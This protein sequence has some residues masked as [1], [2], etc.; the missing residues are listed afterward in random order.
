MDVGIARLAE[1]QHGV[2]ARRQLIAIG[3]DRNRIR[4]RLEQGRLHPIHRGVYAVGHRALTR[5]GRWMAAVLACGPGAA[6]SHRAAAALWGLRSSAAAIDVSIT[7]R[8]G[9]E[10]RCGIVLH[11]VQL[12]RSEVTEHAGIPVTTPA[13]VLLDLAAILPPRDIARAVEA[14]ERARVFDLDALGELFA[15]YP[16]RP[17]TKALTTAI[18]LHRPDL[19]LTRSE[20]ERRFLE[21][22]DEHGVDAPL[23]N[24]P[25]GPYVADFLWPG[26]R[27]IVESDGAETHLT[28]TAFERDRI[29]DAELT[30]AGFRVVRLSYRRIADQPAAVAETIRALLR[31]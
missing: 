5:H 21:L 19:E 9:R 14:A 8:S 1:R 24:A 3:V 16:R 11:H 30:V 7:S 27:L 6:L 31:T 22:C 28:R 20:L 26:H 17:G 23:V 29:R 12:D 13:R 4:R 2:V 18:A 25:V 10:R 15:R